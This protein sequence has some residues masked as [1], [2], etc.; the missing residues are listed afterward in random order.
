MVYVVGGGLIR[1]SEFFPTG[2]P[3]QKPAMATENETSRSHSLHPRDGLAKHRQY[4]L[5]CFHFPLCGPWKKIVLFSCNP[6]I[7]THRL[8]LNSRM[9]YRS[10]LSMSS[11]LEA[12]PGFVKRP[13]RYRAKKRQVAC[14][15]G[16]CGSCLTFSAGF[17]AAIRLQE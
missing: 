13:W 7:G 2:S 8:T 12:T 1:R 16:T 9:V 5:V 14:S 10:R 3:P 6:H 4:S 11:E 15:G 17:W